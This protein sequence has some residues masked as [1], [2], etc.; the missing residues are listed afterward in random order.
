METLIKLALF[1][2]M[3]F[4]TYWEHKLSINTKFVKSITKTTTDLKSF[5]MVICGA[6][7]KREPTCHI[8]NNKYSTD[9]Q[10][11]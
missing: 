11:I 2:S 6:I 5:G 9:L 7:P 10:Y 8:T 3:M 1:H 4:S